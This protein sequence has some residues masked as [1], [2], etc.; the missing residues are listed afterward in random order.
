MNKFWEWMKEKKYS[1]NYVVMF[2]GKKGTLGPIPKQMMIGYMLE[3]LTEEKGQAMGIGT[4]DN[5]RIQE[6]YAFESIEQY[7]HRLV[8]EIKNGDNI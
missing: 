1:K 2:S 4:A 5:K 3:Y 8:K 7:Y 6:G